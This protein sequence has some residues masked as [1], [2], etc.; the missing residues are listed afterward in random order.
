MDQL[1]NNYIDQVLDHQDYWTPSS[2]ANLTVLKISKKHRNIVQSD[3]RT[4]IN[5]EI[6]RLAKSNNQRAK[7]ILYKYT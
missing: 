2:F 6:S 7:T 1:M 5:N 4:H 3:Y